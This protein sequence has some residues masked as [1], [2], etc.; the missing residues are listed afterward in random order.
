MTEG[1]KQYGDTLNHAFHLFNFII[2]TGKCNANY[3][4]LRIRLFS[5]DRYAACL[6]A[7]HKHCII[8]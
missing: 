2:A 4:V 3:N 6:V 7:Y 8:M 1:R 5:N